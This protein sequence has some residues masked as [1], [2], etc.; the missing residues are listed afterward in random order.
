MSVMPRSAVIEGTPPGSLPATVGS[1]LPLLALGLFILLICLERLVDIETF[2]AYRV[3]G[4]L[5]AVAVVLRGSWSLDGFARLAL[6][7]L[8]C[9]MLLGLPSAQQSAQALQS[10]GG[11]VALYGFGLVTYIVFTSIGT[12]ASLRALGM[13]LFFGALLNALAILAGKGTALRFEGGLRY[14]GF[15]QSPTHAATLLALGILC[16]GHLFQINPDRKK[17]I[18]KNLA[19]LAGL[20]LLGIAIFRTGSR[21]GLIG[22]AAAV[23]IQIATSLAPRRLLLLW[24]GLIA[25]AALFSWLAQPSGNMMMERFQT[26][27]AEGTDVRVYVWQSGLQAFADSGGLGLGMGQYSVVHQQYFADKVF[28]RKGYYA[29]AKLNLHN[30]LLAHLVE[31]GIIGLAAFVAMLVLLIRRAWQ[32]ADHALRSLLLAAMTL[33]LA[34]GSL[35]QLSYSPLFWMTAAMIALATRSVAPLSDSRSVLQPPSSS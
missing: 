18:W 17:R 23:F 33:L 25:A 35:H 30:D 19:I 29:G 4:F 13:V 6:L 27:I 24:A 3:W 12:R 15:F 14:A 10:W 21:I 32:V 1:R 5:L 22:A 20:L 16:L 7:S 26:K 34:V 2:K 11:S 9:G 28:A 31:H 8:G